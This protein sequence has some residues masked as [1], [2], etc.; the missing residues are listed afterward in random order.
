[1]E[2]GILCHYGMR[3]GWDAVWLGLRFFSDHVEKFLRI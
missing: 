3:L 1:M 2:T